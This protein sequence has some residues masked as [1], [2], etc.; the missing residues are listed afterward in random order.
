[1]FT[2]APCTRSHAA[3]VVGDPLVAGA[4]AGL[5]KRVCHN[6]IAIVVAVIV[7]CM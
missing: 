4:A 5:C 3:A 1:M 7:I 6:I 2:V